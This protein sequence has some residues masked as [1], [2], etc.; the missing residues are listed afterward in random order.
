MVRERVS[1]RI[2]REGSLAESAARSEPYSVLFDGDCPVCRGAVER[3]KGWDREGLLEFLPS[4]DPDCRS[5]F[6][7]ISPETLREAIHLVGPTGETWAGA[8][9]VEELVRLLPGW[10]R[11]SWFFRLP[12]ARFFSRQAYGMIARNRYRIVCSDH[13]PDH[14]LP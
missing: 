3:L 7:W 1:E 4:R 10:R 14:R 11:A 9:A 2:E 8:R 12:L 5:R 13:C 6:P